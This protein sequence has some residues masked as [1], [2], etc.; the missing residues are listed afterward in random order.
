MKVIRLQEASHSAQWRAQEL[1]EIVGALTPVLARGEASGWDVG[2][3]ESGDPQFYLLGPAPEEAC[4]ICI[5]RI[6]RLYILEDGEGHLLLDTC[7]LTALA[8]RAAATLRSNK[9][10]LVARVVLAWCVAKQ[11]FHDRVE[12]LLAEG[13]DMLAHFAPQLASLA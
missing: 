4:E 6:G 9:M 10:K 11:F 8:E 3:T 1:N 12:P 7:D 5:S 13:E 2:A